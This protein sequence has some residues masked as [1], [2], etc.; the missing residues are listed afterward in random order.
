MVF[1]CCAL[2]SWITGTLFKSLHALFNWHFLRYR[3]TI[4]GT[5]STE[6]SH[7][8]NSVYNS[9]NKNNRSQCCGYV[10]KIRIW[11]NALFSR[12]IGNNV[13]L[14]H[15]RI[16]GIWLALWSFV[17]SFLPNS[18][19]RITIIYVATYAF[20]T[21][22]IFHV[23]DSSANCRNASTEFSGKRSSIEISFASSNTSVKIFACSCRRYWCM[24]CDDDWALA[25]VTIELWSAP[26]PVASWD[27]VCGNAVAFYDAIG[28]IIGVI[29]FDGT[30]SQYY[31]YIY[32]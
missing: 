27:A 5:F 7:K 8:E 18:P 23:L 9:H 6:R 30:L 15:S 21:I 1:Y 31:I 14:L 10:A 2:S 29:L 17:V 28:W 22:S 25:Y 19:N 26:S 16:T 13:R 3:Q 20:V 4:T 24:E 32:I 11:I 12:D